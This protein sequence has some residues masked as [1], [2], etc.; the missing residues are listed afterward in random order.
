VPSHGRRNWTGAF[1]G[2]LKDVADL[3]F[4]SNLE[5]TTGSEKT[6]RQNPR[7]CEDSSGFVGLN[8]A[9]LAHPSYTRRNS[10]LK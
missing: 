8:S 5:K 4:Q 3:G 6:G 7:V 9:R 10:N 2:T 1:W